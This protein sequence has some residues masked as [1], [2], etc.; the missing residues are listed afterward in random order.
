MPNNG[1]NMEN[2]TVGIHSTDA[3]AGEVK[4]YSF[5]FSM[6]ARNSDAVI[7]RNHGSIISPRRLSRVAL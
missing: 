1:I 7:I 3:L 4:G 6:V 2:I 5:S